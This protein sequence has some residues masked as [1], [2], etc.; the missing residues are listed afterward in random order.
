MRCIILIILLLSWDLTFTFILC[1]NGFPDDHSSRTRIL[2]ILKSTIKHH[3]CF[4]WAYKYSIRKVISRLHRREFLV[5]P[6]THLQSGVSMLIWHSKLKP[7]NI[8][9]R[10]RSLHFSILRT[11][12]RLI[13]RSHS[14]L[15]LCKLF[16]VYFFFLLLKSE[17]TFLTL[18]FMICVE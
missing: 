17:P 15:Q 18:L 1:D 10:S 5:K 6:L 9:C 3:I 14:N 4:S 8:W 2:A 16:I 12:P 13:L 7:I 11:L